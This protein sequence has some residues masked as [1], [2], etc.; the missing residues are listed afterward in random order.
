MEMGATGRHHA[1]MTTIIDPARS[2]LA[3]TDDDLPHGGRDPAH[4]LYAHAAGVLA[5]AQAL[6]AAADSPGAVAALAPTLACLETSLAALAHA[7]ARLRSHALRRLEDPVLDTVDRPRHRAELA[8]ELER[9]A[10]VMD[11]GS[12]ACTH[13]REAIDPVSD[14]LTASWARG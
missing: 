8:F 2:I 9:L 14:E 6:E 11:Q 12:F 5:N 4:V 3:H 13:A 7:T 1:A 10:G